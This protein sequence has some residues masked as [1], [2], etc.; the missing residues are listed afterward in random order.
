MRPFKLNREA[1]WIDA[2]LRPRFQ[3]HIE[4]RLGC[5]PLYAGVGKLTDDLMEHI[6]LENN[7]LF[8]NF[9]GSPTTN[10]A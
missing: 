4:G 8:P 9:A 7:L 5:A 1:R 3:H 2:Q 6:H 10:A